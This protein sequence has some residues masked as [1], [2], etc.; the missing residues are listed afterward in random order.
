MTKVPRSKQELIQ[1]LNKHVRLLNE[2]YKK[3][4]NEGNTDYL[5]EIVG[6]IR[7]L[8]IKSRRN[9]PLLV[10]LI[11]KYGNFSLPF[12]KPGKTYNMTLQ[13]YVDSFCCAIAVPSIGPT[14]LSIREFIQLW[15]N[16]EGSAH[17]DWELD[18][19]LV[20]IKNQGIFINAL[21]I[22]SKQLK[23]TSNIVLLFAAKF[24]ERIN[25]N[26]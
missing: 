23:I 18:E 8:A 24:F 15:A 3:A 21:P 17:E 6:K 10:N 1:A 7:L 19:R 13:E 16:Q 20:V 9:K 26:L 11:S 25:S 5:G 14:V 12:E 2:Y 4:F 22:A